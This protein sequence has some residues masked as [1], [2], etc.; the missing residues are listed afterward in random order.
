MQFE[1]K[2]LKFIWDSNRDL[3]TVLPAMSDSDV[4]FC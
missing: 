1:I 2:L 4:M 3:A